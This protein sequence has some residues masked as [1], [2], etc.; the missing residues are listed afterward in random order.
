M[1]LPA[2]G[3]PTL[4]ASVAD[5]LADV[6]RLARADVVVAG[7]PVRSSDLSAADEAAAWAEAINPDADVKA[8]VDGR[9]V[10]LVVDA[11]SSLWPVTV[12]A[13]KLRAAGGTAVLPLLLHR[14]P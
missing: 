13:S 9:S 5:H 2:A 4:T 10:L 11:S 14:R 1:T 7:A 8:C 12:A 3:Y 6:G